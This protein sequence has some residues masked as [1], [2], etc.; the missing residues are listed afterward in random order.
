MPG[1]SRRAPAC[2]PAWATTWW[3]AWGGTMRNRSSARGLLAGPRRGCACRTGRR[4]PRA[5][6]DRPR[7]NHQRRPSRSILLSLREILG[8]LFS[9][10]GSADPLHVRGRCTNS[11]RA[12]PGYRS[13]ATALFFALSVLVGTF[14]IVRNPIPKRALAHHFRDARVH[15]LVGSDLDLVAEPHLRSIQGILPGHLGLLGAHRGYADYRAQSG[16]S[17]TSLHVAPAVLGLG[18]HRVLADLSG[19]PS[20]TAPPRGH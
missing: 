1:V 10:R 3:R 14:I 17:P 7:A 2:P 8:S 11:I 20:L 9:L 13:I 4:C 5:R 18:R 19:G 12:S 15:R 6:R 16:A